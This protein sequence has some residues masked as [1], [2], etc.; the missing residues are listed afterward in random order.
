MVIE[1]LQTVMATRD[2]FRNFGT[3]WGDFADLNEIGWLWF[4]VPILGAIISMTAQ[5]FSRGVSGF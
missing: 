2:A 5:F 3:G 1:V 4:S